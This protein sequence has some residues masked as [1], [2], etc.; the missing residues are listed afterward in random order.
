M[1]LDR[2]LCYLLS[3]IPFIPA[4]HAQT[5]VVDWP[6]KSLVSSPAKINKKVEASIV[7]QNVNDIL[8]H[9]S[10]Q[11]VGT[12]RA[13]DDFS[14]IA[15]AFSAAKVAGEAAGDPCPPL[16]DAAQKAALALGTTRDSFYKLP[17]TFTASCSVAK[18]C[19]IGIKD[20]QKKW[21]E[22]VQPAL[23]TAQ[24]SIDDLNNGPV[25]C[26]NT[27]GK[28]IADMQAAVNDIKQI[29]NYVLSD[30]H[31]VSVT[32]T[33]EPDTDYSVTIRELYMS[34]A[35]SSGTVTT[36]DAVVVSFSP[37]TDRLTLSAGA[38]FSEIQNRGYTSQAEPNATNTGTQNVLVVSGTSRLTPLATAL[39]NYEIPP[40]GNLTLSGDNWGLAVSTG[41]TLQFGS[42]SGT[43]SFGYFLGAGVHLYHRFYISPG[44]HI[45]QFADYP[46]GF[47][48]SGQLVPTGLGTPTPVNRYTVRFAFGVTYKA[49]DLSA[50]GLSTT[51]TAAATSS[52]KKSTP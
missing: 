1:T 20:T 46:P 18:P 12:P 30:S 47:T 11:V 43:S 34:S 48:S 13:D 52:A 22:L 45:G 25:A 28:P 29:G 26:T 17:E 41:P 2:H 6:G 35:S 31:N 40:I 50:L 21:T 38:L 7:I 14:A 3:L 36:A 49:H 4:A 37:A 8:Y 42:K 5:V 32:R 19:S 24:S 9:Y 23:H 51:A 16:L 27:Y 33:L 15:K 39:L 10:I 44:I